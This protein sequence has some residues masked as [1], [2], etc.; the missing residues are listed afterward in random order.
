MFII[1][2]NQEENCRELWLQLISTFS[3]VKDSLVTLGDKTITG[4]DWL[5]H[6]QK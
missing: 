1:L 2:E 3:H 4:E 5:R 6:D